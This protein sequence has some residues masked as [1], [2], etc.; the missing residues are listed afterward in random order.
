MRIFFNYT[1]HTENSGVKSPFEIF[2]FFSIPLTSLAARTCNADRLAQRVAVFVTDFIS[3]KNG[4]LTPTH[5]DQLR[6]F[7]NEVEDNYPGMV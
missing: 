6:S 5:V 4:F 2:F 3:S 1:Q 7:R